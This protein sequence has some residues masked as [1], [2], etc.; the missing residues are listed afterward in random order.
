MENTERYEAF[1][2]TEIATLRKK[3]QSSLYMLI[4][5]GVTFMGIIAW[6]V[7]RASWGTVVAMIIGALL[8]VWFVLKAQLRG[9]QS[10]NRDI[11]EGKKKIVVARVDSQRQDIKETSN[12]SDVVDEAIGLG[13]STGMSYSYLVKVGG[14]EFKV[15]ENQ[16][17]KCKPGH[18]V[19]IEL[20]P[21]SEHVFSLKAL[22]K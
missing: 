11:R 6:G 14:K 1:S 21:H 20:A 7:W 15:S 19:E 16:Y 18:L 8:V 17:Y 12:S 10:L 3:S 4:F 5:V 22:E 2:P 9:V 13:G